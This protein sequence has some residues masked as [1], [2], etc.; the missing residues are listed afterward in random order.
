MGLGF[1]LEFG[2]VAW[3]GGYLGVL[4]RVSSW[5][6]AGLREIDVRSVLRRD[7]VGWYFPAVIEVLQ[8]N[9]TLFSSTTK[10]PLTSNIVGL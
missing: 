9:R 10:T 3:G 4:T 5:A 8:K 7:A 2:I 6:S 1:S